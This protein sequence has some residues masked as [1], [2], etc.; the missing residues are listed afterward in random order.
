MAKVVLFDFKTN[1]RL[2]CCHTQACIQRRLR[3]VC[4]FLF[5][6]LIPSA[7]FTN[8]LR[9]DWCYTLTS[10]E[11]IKLLVQQWNEEKIKIAGWRKDFDVDQEESF[12]QLQ[13]LS[14]KSHDFKK[15]VY[16]FSAYCTRG[17]CHHSP[18]AVNP[19]HVVVFNVVV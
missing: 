7:S 18:I 12:V 6:E 16:N 1:T 17:S 2:A 8:F 5:I 10:P 13:F 11:H 14:D 3:K 19:G 4:T 9:N 15:A